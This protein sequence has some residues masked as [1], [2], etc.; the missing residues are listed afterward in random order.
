MG[1]F[2]TPEEAHTCL[3]RVAEAE[4]DEKFVTT[5]IQAKCEAEMAR[6]WPLFGV[7]LPG[8]TERRFQCVGCNLFGNG[9][10]LDFEDG[11]ILELGREKVDIL[12]FIWS[13][14]CISHGFTERQKLCVDRNVFSRLII[15]FPNEGI[16][17]LTYKLSEIL[18]KLNFHL[19]NFKKLDYSFSIKE[20][21]T[22]PFHMTI[23][24]LEK[25][26]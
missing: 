4:R 16:R 9:K 23:P 25:L 8:T 2:K 15:K 1:S 12:N 17:G 22:F 18:N 26:L 10:T 3:A 7:C 19:Y 11:L 14:L 6:F 24:I 5:G 13:K 21:L 20:K